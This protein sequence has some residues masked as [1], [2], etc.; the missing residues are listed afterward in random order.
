MLGSIAVRELPST[1]PTLV[2]FDCPECG[3]GQLARVLI[4]DED[5]DP[6]MVC[7]RGCEA[8]FPLEDVV[9]CVEQ[10]LRR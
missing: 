3:W 1:S 4:W 6:A 7:C 8:F 10:P 5:G 9:W 2:Q